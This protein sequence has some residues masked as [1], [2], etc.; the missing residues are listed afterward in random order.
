MNCVVYKEATEGEQIK[1]GKLE[2]G[3]NTRIERKQTREIKY[4]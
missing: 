2:N 3:I 1:L 4:S